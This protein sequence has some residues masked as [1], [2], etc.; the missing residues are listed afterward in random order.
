MPEELFK[1]LKTSILPQWKIC[2]FSSLIV[3]LVAHIYKLTNWLPNWDSL[4]FRY[5]PQNMVALGRWFLPVVCAPSSF[6]DLPWLAG[7]ITLLLHGLG[8]VCICKMF[9][10]RKNT[11][12]ALIGAAVISFPTVT[13]LLMYNYV[14]DGYAFAF[15]LSCMA[16]MLLTKEKPGY[17]VSV[18]CIALSAG[19]YQA[20]VTVTVM[21]LLCYLITE[22]MSEASKA[23][24]LIVKALKFLAA[25]AAGMVLYYLIMIVALKLTN[26]ELLEYQGMSN[27]LSLGSFD[28]MA[29]LYV[30][31]QSFTNYFFDFSG[32]ISLF[33]LLNCL[34]F[35]L[36]A[37]LYIS[38]AVRQR[39]KLPKLLIIAVC[40]VLLPIGASV[41]ALINSSVDYHNLMKMGFFVFYL[42]L[43]LQYEKLDFKAPKL[44]AAKAWAIIGIACV[45]VFNNT[46]IA[47]I[48]YHKLNMAYEKSYGVL[49]RIADR[50][51]QTEGA[52]DC[53]RVLV[54]GCLP[55]MILDMAVILLAHGVAWE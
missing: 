3:G 5:D 18:I 47:N 53:D 15:F 40:V 21:L 22:A 7:L 28:V 9:K 13:S 20:Y 6:Y 50:I 23:S 12:A 4:V 29:V 14:A 26:T 27:A 16:A 10:V 24:K 38:D 44:N 31:K 33:A 42:F 32:G 52:K 43:L 46:V 36:T 54:L 1:K 25:G 8:A 17:V 2:F 55:G 30:I 49:L 39:I 11:T 45:L 41:L 51:E 48:S 34:I 19:I 35:V 37:V